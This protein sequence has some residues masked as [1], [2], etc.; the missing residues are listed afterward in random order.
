M[1]YIKLIIFRLMTRKMT[2]E[3]F[4]EFIRLASAGYQI[5]K[6]NNPFI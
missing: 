5:S 4:A 1:K 2:Q 6:G 3:E